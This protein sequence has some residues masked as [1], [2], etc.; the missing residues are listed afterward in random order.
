MKPMMGLV[1]SSVFLLIGIIMGPIIIAAAA[2][3]G[4]VTAGSTGACFLSANAL[5]TLFPSIYY[6]VLILVALTIAGFSAH[7]A[8]SAFARALWRGPFRQPAMMVSTLAVT[9]LFGLGIQIASSPQAFADAACL[10]VD[11]SRAMTANLN[12][13]GFKITSLGNATA[14]TDALNRNTGDTRYVDVTGDTL[15]GALLNN[16]AFTDPV[17][18]SRVY[19]TES[20]FHITANNSQIVGAYRAAPTVSIADGKTWSGTG[21]MG[22]ISN[23]TI[24]GGGASGTLSVYADHW[25]F[26]GVVNGGA[27]LGTRCAYCADPLTSAG[28]NY[29]LKGT[30]AGLVLVSDATPSTS[31]TTGAVVTTG[32]LAAG[33]DSTLAG[34]VALGSGNSALA[35]ATNA[36]LVVNGKFATPVADGSVEYYAINAGLSAFSD[37]ANVN[38]ASYFYTGRFTTTID[39]ANTANYTS[40]L[41]SLKFHL[42]AESTTNVYNVANYDGIHF[43]DDVFMGASTVTNTTFA[44]IEPLSFATNSYILDVGSMTSSG[45]NYIIR[46]NGGGKILLNDTTA[47]TSTTTGAVVVAGGGAFGGDFN[48]GGGLSVG[49]TTPQ[50][51]RY[52]TLSGS[53][54]GASSISL[55]HE[56]GTLVASANSTAMQVHSIS[57]TSFDTGVANHT[58]LSA[59]GLRVVPG[60]FSKAHSGTIDTAAG[61][62]ID[63]PPTI[64]SAN[65]AMLVKGGDVNL[66]GSGSLLAQGATA[67]FVLIPGVATGKPSGVPAN[68]T[69]GAL[70]MAY[71]AVNNQLCIYNAAWKCVTL[72]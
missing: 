58:G 34:H 5:N 26:S 72:A 11:G 15:T 69:T 21:V 56:I 54:T 53:I 24:S 19:N 57:T 2:G 64:G 62:E 4:Q 66:A 63:G 49:E 67:G 12:M 71:D 3:S 27:T 29:L 44:Y 10:L 14:G 65:Y 42:R 8:V 40:R 17:S 61:I 13:G 52:S 7:Q 51:G 28:T 22:Y 55:V 30:G 36:Q 39:A 32:G 37:I 33:D 50:A 20:T 41:A 25:V 43:F 1:F 70:P 45:N 48:V 47:S 16:A 23:P 38:N 60:N 18:G 59:W 68:L 6:A 31:R 35:P 46:G 9:A